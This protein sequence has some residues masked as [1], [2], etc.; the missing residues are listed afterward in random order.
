MG[1]Y[2]FILAINVVLFHLLSVRGIGPAAVISFFVLSGFLMTLIMQ[3]SYGYSITGFIKYAQNRFLRLFPIYWVL[4]AISLLTIALVGDVSSRN[5]HYAMTIPSSIGEWLSNVTLVFWSLQPIDVTPR[6]APAT[7]ALTIEL[8]FYLLIGL[9]LSRTKL[10]TTIWLLT[11]I[12]Y[13][14]YYNLNHQLGLAYGSIFSASLPFSIGAFCYH[15][16]FAIFALLDKTQVRKL[17]VFSFIVNLGLLATAPLYLPNSVIWKVT[18]LCN[19]LN[20]VMS[21]LMAVLLFKIDKSIDSK[22]N[23]ILGDMSYPV[24]VFH[25]SGALIAAALIDNFDRQSNEMVIFLI[26]IL[27]TLGIS[28]SVEKLISSKLNTIRERIKR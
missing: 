11:S 4:G 15:Y 3:S 21:A 9:G 8:F 10:I 16:R 17:L 22:W 1:Y 20:I 14:I 28:Y 5:F 24:Y 2:R 25:W 13:M 19:F 26:G 6:L 7:W 27:V 18:L 12:V 23:K